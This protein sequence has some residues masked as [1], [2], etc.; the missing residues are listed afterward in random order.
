MWGDSGVH[1]DTWLRATWLWAGTLAT[2]RILGM[3][4]LPPTTD[5]LGPPVIPALALG[6]S[7]PCLIPSVIPPPG[8]GFRED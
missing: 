4:T 2:H 7:H 6:T 8:Q 1:P 3:R 5:L